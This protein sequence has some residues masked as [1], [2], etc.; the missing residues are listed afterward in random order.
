[1]HHT[2][3]TE[4]ASGTEGPL[5][6]AARFLKR[7]RKARLARWGR[8]AVATAVTAAGVGVAAGPALAT[9]QD[10]SNRYQ[11][12][13][14]DNTA[15]PTFN[16]LLGINEYG[17]IAGYFGSG[18][19]GHPNQ[20]YLLFP[21]YRQWDFADGNY[22]Q[23]VQTQVTGLNDRGVTVGFWSDQNNAGQNGNPPSNDNFGFYAYRGQYHN[24]NFPNPANGNSN[25]PV[26]QLL[27]VND[28]DVAVGFYND[29]S[30]NSHGYT[31]NIRT[32]QYN[33]ITISGASNV[34]AAA[35]NNHGDIAGFTTDAQSL[36]HGYLLRR[37]GQLITLNVPGASQ[38]QALGVNDQD[39][40][41]GVYTVGTGSSA[42][43]H[44]FT[45][46]PGR[47]FQ[48]VNDRSGRDSTTING[49]NDEGQ[50]VGFYVDGKGNT[51]GFLATPDNHR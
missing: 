4:R 42:K 46:M 35:I 12:R 28:N 34:T 22:P 47:G 9:P 18:D 13:T 7:G 51:D 20:G 36:N 50:L 37:D 19:A 48:T 38:T 2:H 24:V 21:N 11:F 40:V 44:G 26:N 14:I 16:Q 49:V 5:P 15:D 23:S 17:V 8:V 31:Y 30:G 1:M 27:G 25:P 6:R 45:W 29:A 32:N 43:M 41:V 33:E 39:E 3:A 10:H